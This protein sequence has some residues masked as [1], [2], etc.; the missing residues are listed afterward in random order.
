MDWQLSGIIFVSVSYLRTH[1][2][3]ER[4]DN[5]VG[6]GVCKLDN[7]TKKTAEFCAFKTSLYRN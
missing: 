6:T 1:S 4:Q 5:E 3:D 2:S 7:L